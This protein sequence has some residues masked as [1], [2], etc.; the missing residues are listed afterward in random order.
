MAPDPTRRPVLSADYLSA[1]GS[2]KFVQNLPHLAPKHTTEEKT[3]FLSSLRSSVVNLQEDVN[4]FLTKKMDE[5]KAS[6][7]GGKSIDDKKE[8]ENYGEEVVED[9]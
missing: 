6:A 4:T 9:I 2:T 7:S 8:E 1:D 3:V 5:E